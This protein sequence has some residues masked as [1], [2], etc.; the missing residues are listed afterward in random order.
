[1]NVPFLSIIEEYDITGKII[2][3]KK[4]YCKNSKEQYVLMNNENYNNIYNI[5]INE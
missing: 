5:C 3:K 2:Y 4:I 1:M